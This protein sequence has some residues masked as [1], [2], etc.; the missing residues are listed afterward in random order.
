MNNP[1][2]WAVI[3]IGGV[4]VHLKLRGNRKARQA[5]DTAIG[6]NLRYAGAF[7]VL[8]IV[9]LLLANTFK[10]NEPD[11]KKLR[12]S[13]QAYADNLNATLP[14]MLDEN[15]Q[16]DSVD[17]NSGGFIFR[18]TALDLEAAGVDRAAFKQAME[19]QLLLSTCA[20]AESRV[21]IYNGFPFSYAYHD[22]H[23][24]RFAT[25]TVTPEKCDVWQSS[26]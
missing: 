23:G 12:A 10:S 17:L 18:Y 25:V 26:R 13:L 8:L 3:I 6:R 9:V 22:W 1:Y 16:F 24:K 21:Y 2:F 20:N 4:L 15:T 5:T 7:V 11:R 19:P 14:M